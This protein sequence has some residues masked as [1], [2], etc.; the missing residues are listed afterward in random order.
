MRI[1]NDIFDQPESVPVLESMKEPPVVEWLIVRGSFNLH[2]LSDL[3]VVG[4]V[5]AKTQTEAEQRAVSFLQHM[6]LDQ[7]MLNLDL[8]Q[9]GGYWVCR[10]PTELIYKVEIN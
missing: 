4:T 5:E 10:K 7:N 3:E 6:M 8:L 1:I 2:A 9:P